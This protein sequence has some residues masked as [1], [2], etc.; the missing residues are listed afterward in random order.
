[1]NALRHGLHRARR[2]SPIG[3]H[4]RLQLVF[5]KEIVDSLDAQTPVE[6]QFAFKPSPTINGASTASGPLRTACSPW[7][8]FE[9]ARRILAG[10]NNL[11][12]SFSHDGRQGLSRA[13]S[14]AFVNPVA[15][16]EQ[17]LDRSMKDALR[18]LKEL[19]DERRE[20]RKAEMDD[21][22]RLLKAQQMKGLPYDPK[23]DRVF[24]YR[25]RRNRPGT[26]DRREGASILL[27]SPSNRT[28]TSPDTNL[29][30]RNSPH[31]W[32]LETFL[33][34]RHSV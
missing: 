33:R 24:V 21:A 18:Q 15:S 17:R 16:Y 22:I 26:T 34:M 1:M 2:R 32:L 7:G 25:E 11:R 9:A 27:E 12:G 8:I 3:R 10:T 6:R 28:S 30:G 29:P 23:E 20:L 14:Q 19:Q 31:K 13:L 5:S 4:G